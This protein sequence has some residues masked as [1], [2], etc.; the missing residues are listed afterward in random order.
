MQWNGVPGQLLLLLKV[1]KFRTSI[2]VDVGNAFKHLEVWKIRVTDI[3]PVT[4][5]Y[6]YQLSQ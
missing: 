5:I 2:I 1:W 6:N 3:P 4:H